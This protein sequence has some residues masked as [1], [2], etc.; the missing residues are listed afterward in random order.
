V[1]LGAR[2]TARRLRVWVLARC[3]APSQITDTLADYR[4]ASRP[5][6]RGRPVCLRCSRAACR[7]RSDPAVGFRL[8]TPRPRIRAVGRSLFPRVSRLP[9]GCE[10][11]RER[12]ASS[13]GARHA[14]QPGS[15]PAP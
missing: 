2:S 4:T 7:L 5:I 15:H 10:S 8:P 6:V 11:R 9:S 13:A 12:A 3:L 1:A 14:S